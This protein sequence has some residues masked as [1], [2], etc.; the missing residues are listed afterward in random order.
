MVNSTVSTPAATTRAVSVDVLGVQFVAIPL[1]ATTYV[2]G[3]MSFVSM[4]ASLAM[5]TAP[6]IPE[7]VTEYPSASRCCPVVTLRTTKLP[8]GVSEV[9]PPP[10]QALRSVK[11]QSSLA[12]DM[13]GRP[14]SK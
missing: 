12:C 9:D 7:M 14:G 4:A 6:D 2:P 11:M 10:P 5:G 8:L 1:K 13:S 3:A